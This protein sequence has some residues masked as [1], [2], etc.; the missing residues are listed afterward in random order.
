MMKELLG[1]G[2]RVDDVDA[3]H[4]GTCVVREKLLSWPPWT[5]TGRCAGREAEVVEYFP[6]HVLGLD[7]GDKAHGAG[8][9]GAHHHVDGVDALEKC[10]PLQ[11]PSPGRVIWTGGRQGCDGERKTR[12][13]P[14]FTTARF[15]SAMVGT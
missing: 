4:R 10:R 2:G 11:T 9:P 6:S 14:S 5:A 7:H 13:T 8:A 1:E 12:K 15:D 3:V